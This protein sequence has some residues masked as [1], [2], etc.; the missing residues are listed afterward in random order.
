MAREGSD[1]HSKALIPLKK[2]DDFTVW[3][4][5]LRVVA[6][7]EN[8]HLLEMMDDDDPFMDMEFKDSQGK[9]FTCNQACK[10]LEEGDVDK[11][12]KAIEAMKR[13]NALKIRTLNNDKA[14]RRRLR[15][16]R[17]R[18][19]LSSRSPANADDRNDWQNLSFRSFNA[20]VL[21]IPGPTM[22][23][24]ARLPSCSSSDPRSVSSG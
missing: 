3:L 11:I 21:S 24:R 18:R 17:R 15:R 20:A 6:S 10:F 19:S 13:K 14:K 5:N 12:E 2:G 7:G 9:T 8:R 23:R 4:N 16:Q 22:R 1:A